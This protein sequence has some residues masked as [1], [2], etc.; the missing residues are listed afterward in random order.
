M[1]FVYRTE[2][3]TE[4]SPKK[5]EFEVGPG[6]YLPIFD[7]NANKPNKVPFLAAS[8][9]IGLLEQAERKEGPGPGAYYHDE[10]FE[11]IYTNLKKDREQRIE[12]A[13]DLK[14][15]EKIHS[16]TATEG[17]PAMMLKKNAESLGFLGKD[18]RFKEKD[19]D[20]T[21]GP[22]HY[23]KTKESKQS[24]IRN[25]LT[26]FR[27]PKKEKIESISRVVS[28]PTRNQAFGYEIE[29]ELNVLLNDDP[30]KFKKFKGEKNDTVGPGNYNVDQPD[31]WLKKGGTQWSKSKT[32]KTLFGQNEKENKPKSKLGVPLPGQSINTKLSKSFEVDIRDIQNNLKIV[33]ERSSSATLKKTLDPKNILKSNQIRKKNRKEILEI[34]NKKEPIDMF[35]AF[36]KK[37]ASGTPGPGYYF[38]DRMTSAFRSVKYPEYKQN[39]Q[40][41][42]QRFPDENKNLTVGPGTYFSEK[43]NELKIFKENK[44]G[45]IYPI[46][47]I[48][49]EPLEKTIEINPGPGQYDSVSSFRNTKRN[50]SNYNFGST[51][52]RFV[53]MSKTSKIVT[54]GPGSYIESNSTFYTTKEKWVNIKT[55]NRDSSNMMKRALTTKTIRQGIGKSN[56]PRS[57][58]DIQG[59]SKDII[60]S[61]GTYNPE[62]M[63]TIDYKIKKNSHKFG[64]VEA[65][66]NS[67]IT[68]NRFELKKDDDSLGPGYYYKE[69]KPNT[70]QV[71]P[72]FNS[73]EKRKTI[74]V[75]NDP[76]INTGPGIYNQNSYFDWN[77]KTF[78]ILYL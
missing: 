14:A 34:M 32:K 65:A 6:Q 49:K 26:N 55:K 12:K 31:V 17:F 53:D 50:I 7:N 44:K 27:I 51:E 33:Q 66:F 45:K 25:T 10:I 61:V 19:E 11:K 28:I 56:V 30:E 20:V 62:T 16:M 29:D 60:P 78:N 48:A 67:T 70:A 40:S 77:K 46:S 72:P 73:H 47:T 59:Q 5:E 37:F 24:P 74:E 21:P 64:F 1:A 42:L 18:A 15:L 23:L 38:D 69:K 52:K 58:F 54:P 22:G 43:N 57:L 9:R 39:F 41:N 4:L 76:M 71:Y 63:F 75:R 2:R 35:G 68:Q 8:Q 3:V 36:Q 13:V